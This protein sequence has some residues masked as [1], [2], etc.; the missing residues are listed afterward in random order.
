MLDNFYVGNNIAS[1]AADAA[2]EVM[3]ARTGLPINPMIRKTAKKNIA[4]ILKNFNIS[5]EYITH[6]GLEKLCG[7]EKIISTISKKENKIVTR[8]RRKIQPSKP[9]GDE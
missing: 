3:E 4:G 8:R 7:M 1:Y 2:L 5:G 9:I 6:D